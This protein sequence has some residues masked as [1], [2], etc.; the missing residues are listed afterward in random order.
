MKITFCCAQMREIWHEG[1]VGVDASTNDW[2][3]VMGCIG[4]SDTPSSHNHKVKR[5]PFCGSKMKVR[6]RRNY[7]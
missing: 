5:C 2:Y 3:I 6:Q 4:T 1:N 7:R